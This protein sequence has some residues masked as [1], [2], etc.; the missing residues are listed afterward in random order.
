M[1][2]FNYSNSTNGPIKTLAVDIND[3][4]PE[5]I[6]NQIDDLTYVSALLLVK[7]NGFVIGTLNIPFNGKGVS[8][9]ELA[10]E[11]WSD[12]HTEIKASHQQFKLAQP[13]HL[14]ISGYG[15]KLTTDK[16][17]PFLMEFGPPVSIVVATRNR[18]ASLRLTVQSILELDYPSFNLIIVDNAPSTN[19]TE[20]YITEEFGNDPRVT[21]LRE[22]KPGL[23]AAH[24]KGLS[25]V[26]SPIVAFTD[27]DVTV[28]SNWLTEIVRGFTVNENVAAV[29]GMIWPAK[30]ETSAQI[31]TEQFGGFGK[32]VKQK[33]FGIAHQQ[34]KG[35]LFPYTVG[36]FGSGANMAFKTNI[37]RQIGGFDTALGAGSQG[38]GGDDLDAFFQIITHGFD[39]VYEPNAVVWHTHRAD[40]EG[41]FRQAFGYGVGFTA[42]LTKC[43]AQKPERL[44]FMV[45]KLPAA[46]SHLFKPNSRKNQSK[47]EDFPR[48]LSVQ[49]KKGMLYGPLAYIKGQREKPSFRVK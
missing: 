5:I 13:H 42:F 11:I 2:K 36:E 15:I 1:N 3:P 10:R 23:A 34:N 31:W 20:L 24:N 46:L 32:G 16:V 18:T 45:R 27:D 8:N 43:I 4:L 38:M 39:L 7:F 37:L 47:K 19:E 17:R 44:F 14:P 12:L 22:N 9:L 26:Y 49:E 40:Y 29:T 21:Y 41:L 35:P 25:V 48:E 28:E 33:L 6:P 30:L